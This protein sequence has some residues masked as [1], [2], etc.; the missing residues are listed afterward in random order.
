MS[1]A[2]S[3]VAGLSIGLLLG[4]LLGLSTSPVVAAVVG[5]LVAAGGAYWSVGN[6]RGSDARADQPSS[7]RQLATAALCLACT[8]GL[9]GGLW[10]RTHDVFGLTPTEQVAQWRAAG[11]SE[12]DAQAIVALKAAGFLKAG[13]AS[14][15]Q[16]F[17]AA[18]TTALFGG[19]VK[20]CDQLN[21]QDFKDAAN[22]RIAFANASGDW[23]QLAEAVA[24]LS[25]D[26]QRAALISTWQL[27]CR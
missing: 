18:R 17:T 12:S 1:S 3:I 6:P 23:K 15:P 20:E 11:F 13:A 26:A 16:A 4:V 27:A 19:S 14:A 9:A 21:P 5:A 25:S 2:P 8:V 24:P 7:A 22:L 10:L